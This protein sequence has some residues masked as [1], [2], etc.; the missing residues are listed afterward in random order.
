MTM[1]PRYEG[2]MVAMPSGEF[3]VENQVG[4]P[5]T[6]KFFVWC[7]NSPVGL[8]QVALSVVGARVYSRSLSPGEPITAWRRF[9]GDET[10]EHVFQIYVP[11]VADGDYPLAI[12]VPDGGVITRFTTKAASGTCTA[13][14]KIG[15]TPVTGGVNAVTASVVES[16][17]SGANALA[18]GDEVVVTVS[19]N[20][21]CLGL[22]LQVY[23]TRTR[24]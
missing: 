10:D 12:N 7:I 23:W 2:V 8:F 13:T 22:L 21:A 15:T 18:V 17:P 1:V 24:T 19:A 6:G 16:A 20:A 5:D 11:S 14:L 4:M 9:G 3:W